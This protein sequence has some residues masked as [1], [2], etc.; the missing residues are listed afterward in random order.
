[1]SLASEHLH[2]FH[3]IISNALDVRIGAQCKMQDSRTFLYIR[4]HMIW[5]MC[6]FDSFQLRSTYQVGKKPW[7]SFFESPWSNFAHCILHHFIVCWAIELAKCR[8]SNR[9]QANFTRK[10]VWDM[11]SKGFMKLCNEKTRFLPEVWNIWKKN[12]SQNCQS[13]SGIR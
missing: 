6:E 5:I 13:I 11:K 2:S 8:L 3:Y 12:Y 1:M 7:N 4:I 9:F 10:F